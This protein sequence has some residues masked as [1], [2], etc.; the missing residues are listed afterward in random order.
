MKDG[1]V[2]VDTKR[3]ITLPADVAAAGDFF[4]LHVAPDGSIHLEPMVV[5]PV[6]P[7]RPAPR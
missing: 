6:V 5:V 4:Q 3:R 2:R 1:L 7:V